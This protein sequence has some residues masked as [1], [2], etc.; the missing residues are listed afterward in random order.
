MHF[1]TCNR[2]Q[3]AQNC[4]D[5]MDS[6]ENLSHNLSNTKSCQLLKYSLLA[7]LVH[8]HNLHSVV[9]GAEVKDLASEHLISELSKWTE[10]DGEH[11][12]ETEHI[13]GASGQGGWELSHCLIE[14]DVLE[15]LE[16]KDTMM[17]RNGPF[18]ENASQIAYLISENLM[19]GINYSVQRVKF[20]VHLRNSAFPQ[21]NSWY[22]A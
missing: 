14:A 3:E 10:H 2:N 4:S 8:I 22:R 15:D 21:K 9:H 17:L 13:L 19:K 1:L 12:H 16:G 7:I 18:L 20:M 6:Y 5:Q 11:D